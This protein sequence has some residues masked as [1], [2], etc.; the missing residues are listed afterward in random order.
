M[1]TLYKNRSV[2]FIFYT[3]ICHLILITY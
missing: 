3:Y 1:Y 2:R